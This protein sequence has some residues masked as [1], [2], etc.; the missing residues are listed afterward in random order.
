MYFPYHYFN[1][2]DNQDYYESSGVNPGTEKETEYL[3]EYML[4]TIL[5][6]KEDFLMKF[7][8]EISDFIINT[9]YNH[10]TRVL[11]IFVTL[12][13]ESKINPRENNITFNII[14][15]EKFPEKPPMV[16]CISDVK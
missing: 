7:P 3:D 5:S 11:K 9:K 4:S 13:K 15:N 12:E 14:I 8:P 1:K 10:K 6:I 16:F 2:M